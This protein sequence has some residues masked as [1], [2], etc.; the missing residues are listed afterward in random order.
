MQMIMETVLLI[1]I[2]MNFEEAI[3]FIFECTSR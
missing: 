1:N 3:K 2:I